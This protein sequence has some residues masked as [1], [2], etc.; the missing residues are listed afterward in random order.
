MKCCRGNDLN[1]L[2]DGLSTYLFKPSKLRIPISPKKSPAF[3][4]VR[5]LPVSL[6]KKGTSQVKP[7]IRPGMC[8]CN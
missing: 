8:N 5:T 4:V 2:L 7:F 1:E 6:Q 3:I